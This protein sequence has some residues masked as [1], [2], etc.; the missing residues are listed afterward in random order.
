MSAVRRINIEIKARCPDPERVRG[1]LR[2]LEARFT[3]QDEQVDTYFRVSRGRLKVR[4]GQI[5][6]SLIAYERPDDAGP[7]QSDVHLFRMGSGAAAAALRRALEAALPV[8]VV[9]RKRRDIWFLDNVKIHVDEVEGLGSFLE[10]EAISDPDAPAPG[11]A[12]E[13]GPAALRA[14]CEDLMAALGVEEEQLVS[15][16]Y[17][18]MLLGKSAP[19]AA[20]APVPAREPSPKLILDKDLLTHGLRGLE[21]PIVTVWRIKTGIWAGIAVLALLGWDIVTLFGS[22]PWLP[23]GVKPGLALVVFG[24]LIMV[25]TRLRYRSWRF[26]LREDE[27]YLGRGIFNHIRTIVP[28]KRIQHIDVSQD[29][30]EREFDL[31]RLVVHTAGTRG[32]AVILPGLT[33]DEA[34][35]LRDAMKAFIQDEAL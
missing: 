8:L 33:L 20:P 1:A 27:L 26:A 12:A 17:S 29:I 30:F 7:K 9:V 22:D 2:G 16:S 4:E 3:G 24:G 19:A 18:D 21:K 23:L 34:E 15:T 28:L 25:T 13:P 11:L 10:I 35:R 31:G 32:N 6:Q 5:E 14:Q